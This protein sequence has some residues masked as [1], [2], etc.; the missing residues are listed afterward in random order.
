MNAAPSCANHEG[1]VGNGFYRRTVNIGSVPAGVRVPRTRKL[2]LGLLASA[3][4][5]EGV[6]R[7]LRLMGVAVP[8]DHLQALM[9]SLA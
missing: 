4:S 3:R 9:D 2:I 5:I 7:S 8:E 6:R 1:E